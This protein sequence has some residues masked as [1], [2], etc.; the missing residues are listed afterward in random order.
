[1]TRPDPA[2]FERLQRENAELRELVD[3]YEGTARG[4]AA[5]A[6][7]QGRV[8]LWRDAFVALGTPCRHWRMAARLLLKL[9]ERP[10]H[11]YSLDFLSTYLGGP[12]SEPDRR[13]PQVAACSLRRYLQALELPGALET[14]RNFGYRVS[15]AN[16]QRL[17]AWEAG[18]VDRETAAS[19]DH[20]MQLRDLG[21]RHG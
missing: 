6:E 8:T 18:L 9:I 17:L 21:R 10:G 4:E 7:Y 5:E 11:T 15:P 2:E 20:L 12:G 3:A 14:V 1:M 13:N 19:E 16:C